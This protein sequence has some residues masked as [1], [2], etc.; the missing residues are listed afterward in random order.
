MNNILKVIF[1]NQI[2][3]RGVFRQ[4][5]D[6]PISFVISIARKPTPII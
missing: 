5:P 2:S 6:T 3:R 1:L 4:E